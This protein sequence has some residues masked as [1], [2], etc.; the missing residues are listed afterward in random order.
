VL[1][2]TVL[3]FLPAVGDFVAAQL[4]GGPDEYMVGNLIQQQF[5]S[6]E[7]WPFGAALTAVM[8]AF[9]LVW[10]VLYLRSAAR[11]AA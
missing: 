6:A 11:E 2:G 5:F 8:M 3:V 10:M 1:A 4:L 9:L 7:N